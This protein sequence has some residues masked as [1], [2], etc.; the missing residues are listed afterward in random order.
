MNAKAPNLSLLPAM[1]RDF[2]G[3]WQRL[4]LTDV[5]F[6][7][8][9]FVVLTPLSG[10]LFRSLLAASGNEV[11]SDVDIL[12]FFLGPFG[13]IG[14]IIVGTTWL[15]IVALE[16]AS[17]TAILYSQSQKRRLLPLHALQFAATKLWQVIRLT[18]RMVVLT[19]L[20]IAPFL[21]LAAA[22]YFSLLT[23]HD[24]NYYLKEKPPAF[25]TALVIGGVLGVVLTALLLRLFSGW[26][27]AL[28][29][30]L[31]ENV[32]ARDALRLSGQRV[33]GH[34]IQVILWIVGWFL[35][36]TIVSIL[37]TGIVGLLGRFIIPES[38]ASLHVL[39]LAVGFVLLIWSIVALAVNLL[40]T[41]TFAVMLF[42][43]YRQLGCDE[44]GLA[45]LGPTDE[46]PS[47]A[48]LKITRR[49][50]TIGLV[51]GVVV[52]L[53]VG[54]VALRSVR[55]D[56]DVQIM[57]H[58]GS[59]KAAPENTMAA[60]RQAIEDGA[61][62]VEID[63][64]ETA[65]GEVVVFHDSDFMKVA[66]NDLKI[67]D[68]TMEDLRDIDI[69]TWFDSEFGDQ[70]VPT[71]GEVLDECHGKIGVNIELKY[72][73]HDEQLEQR[74]ADIVTAHDMDTQVKAMSLKIGG[75]RK[76]KSIRPDWEVGSLMSVSA[77]NI[78]N[79]EADFLAVNAS[80]ANRNLIR[81]AH[82]SGKEVYVWTVNDGP[83]MSAMMSR[84]VDGLLT[85][86]PALARTVLEQRAE[87]SAPERLL[88]EVARMLGSAPEFAEQ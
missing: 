37:L 35:A 19:I 1:K 27:F 7:M 12:L 65:D 60:I 43:L 14:L 23:K 68:A 46:T 16:Q 50:V 71:L 75:V 49:R 82:A 63:V 26:F 34:R 87:M 17:L 76:M 36:T 15:G 74:V 38:T 32:Q 6:K 5:A 33:R 40:S 9:A 3:T 85:D 79:I 28:P 72:Y 59:S 13:W 31:F 66:G 53:A 8:L 64:Q 88:L 54:V 58:R 62:W 2:G 10:L 57:A 56:D 77:G 41:T 51:A 42:R 55:V 30:V 73:G 22:V 18:T 48:A 86:K 45:P 20:V 84:G 70:R 67:W 61:D 81:T 80:F 29:M 4:A 11:L 47:N 21:A 44:N 78:K 83:T 69:G 24:I 52:A 25:T 39:A